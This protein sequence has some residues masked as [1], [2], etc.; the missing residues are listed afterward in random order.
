VDWGILW[1]PK[2]FSIQKFYRLVKASLV[3]SQ[4]TNPSPFGGFAKKVFH[5]HAGMNRGSSH[6]WNQYI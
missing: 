4:T 1:L 5:T 3:P 6:R 2:F